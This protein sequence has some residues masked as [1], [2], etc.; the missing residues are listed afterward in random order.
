M[1]RANVP[2]EGIIAAVL[3]WSNLRGQAF[4]GVGTC[5]LDFRFGAGA[6][7]G[8]VTFEMGRIGMSALRTLTAG[9]V[10]IMLVAD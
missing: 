7:V 6:M 10:L 5:V 9:R 3:R 1:V 8:D 4:V 2:P